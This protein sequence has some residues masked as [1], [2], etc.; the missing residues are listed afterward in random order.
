M[1]RER[2]RSHLLR[3]SA[4]GV[5]RNANEMSLRLIM[6]GGDGVA[7]DGIKIRIKIGLVS[8]EMIRIRIFIRKVG[9]GIEGRHEAA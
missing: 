1:R 8:E 5:R 3:S 9:G 6:T 2:E 4:T 7:W